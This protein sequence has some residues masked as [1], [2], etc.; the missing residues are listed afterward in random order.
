MRGGRKEKEL[1][2]ERNKDR[3]LICF[4]YISFC[5]QANGT[6]SGWRQNHRLT[7]RCRSKPTLYVFFFLFSLFF[8]FQYLSSS[9]LFISPPSF[10]NFP[11]PPSNLINVS[12]E[13]ILRELCEAK[14][15][16]SPRP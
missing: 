16:R 9:S 6:K 15:V 4:V 1:N 14:P 5:Y 8:S 7:Q 2:R 11:S 12:S 10:F 13:V 3:L